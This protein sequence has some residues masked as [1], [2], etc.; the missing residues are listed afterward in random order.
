MKTINWVKLLHFNRGRDRWTD[1]A[2]YST[3]Q[4]KR[5]IAAAWNNENQRGNEATTPDK[6]VTN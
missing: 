4:E 2:R 3:G 6:N 1:T 5:S